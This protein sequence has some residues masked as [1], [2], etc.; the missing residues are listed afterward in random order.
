MAVNRSKRDPETRNQKG[1]WSV[2]P[3]YRWIGFETKQLLLL[4]DWAKTEQGRPESWHGVTNGI[5]LND[6][7]FTPIPHT[8]REGGGVRIGGRWGAVDSLV[9]EHEKEYSH[10]LAVRDIYDGE[11]GCERYDIYL[12]N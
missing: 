2:L 6:S 1:R 12:Y 5:C 10:L 8:G 4:Y 7:G 11:R 9:L 3:S